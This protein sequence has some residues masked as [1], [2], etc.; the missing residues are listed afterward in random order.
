M[1]AFAR[2]VAAAARREGLLA[3]GETVLVGLSGGADSCALV[4]ALAEGGFRPLALHINHGLRGAESDRDERAASAAAAACA[5]PFSARRVAVKRRAGESLEAAARRARERAFAEEALRAGVSKVATAHT[6]D[7]QAETVLYRAARGAGPRGLRGILARRPLGEGVE[8]V[9]PLLA[10]SRADARAYAERRGLRWVEDSS[11][12]DSR[13]ARNRIRRDVL[14]ALEAARPGAARHLAALARDA[15]ALEG[16][17]ARE[18]EAALRRARVPGGL[19][20]ATLAELPPA[21]R[22]AAVERA[23]AGAGPLRAAH[24]DALDRLFATPPRRVA[25]LGRGWTANRRGAVLTIHPPAGAP[26][27]DAALPVPGECTLPR[28]GWR[29]AARESRARAGFLAGFVRDKS[30]LEE[31]LDAEAAPGPYTVGP[32]RRGERFRPLGA[33]GSRR[34]SE[35]LKDLDVPR[36]ER[37]ATPVVRDRDGRPVWIVGAR[38]A[39]AAKVTPA[40]RRIVRLAA[41]RAIS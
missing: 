3:R 10:V 8:L 4:A 25:V 38:L 21:V 34:I 27:D 33:P 5:V 30:A 7:D 16:W 17:I 12:S 32:A 19:D 24:R 15:A 28:S 37:A 2:R 6:R 13:F 36:A 40:T 22:H 1:D 23:A 11:N 35:I 29:L 41:V 14:P 20:A 9:R 26:D 31:A 39:E 18:A